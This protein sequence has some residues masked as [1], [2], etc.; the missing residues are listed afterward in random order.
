VNGREVQIPEPSV[1]ALKS[2]AKVKDP[3]GPDTLKR[4]VRGPGLLSVA[5]TV[6][7]MDVPM[8][9]GELSVGVVDKIWTEA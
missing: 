4:K 3:P 6:Q 9:C 5:V 8:T 7:T 2:R 1:P